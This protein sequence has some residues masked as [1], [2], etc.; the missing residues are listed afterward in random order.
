MIRTMTI[1]FA[2]TIASSCM[3]FA[4]SQPASAAQEGP[5]THMVEAPFEDVMLDL[6]DAVVGRG[7]V[8]DYTGNVDKM[9]ERTAEAAGSVTESGTKSPYLHAKY[10]QFCSAKLTHEAVSANP[11]NLS[12][13]PYLVYLYET[14]DQPGTVHIGY[15]KPVFGPS[16]ASHKIETKINTF[17]QAII[18]EVAGVA[19]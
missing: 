7:L 19:N 17:L 13:C 16:K 15:R 10:I 1:A 3:F 14:Q 2:A 5:Q 9:L 18:D 11:Q 8:I 6:Q 12:I 4:V